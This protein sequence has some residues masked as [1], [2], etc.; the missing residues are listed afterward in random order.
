[1][2]ERNVFGFNKTIP[3][4]NLVLSSVISGLSSEANELLEF[5]CQEFLDGAKNENGV[6]VEF[7]SSECKPFTTDA[8][9]ELIEAGIVTVH[10]SD[11]LTSG[12]ALLHCNGDVAV[13]MF[14]VGGMM[15]SPE[16]ELQIAEYA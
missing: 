15:L 11:N 16:E 6:Y 3:S 1:M 2:N 7:D 9:N 4:D 10:H 14:E 13:E 8:V 5:V 12:S